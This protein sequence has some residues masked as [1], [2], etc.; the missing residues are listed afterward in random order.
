M[1]PQIY[2]A[3]QKKTQPAGVRPS[4]LRRH[5]HAGRENPPTPAPPIDRDGSGSDFVRV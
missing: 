1:H 4:I 5:S 2:T 3:F